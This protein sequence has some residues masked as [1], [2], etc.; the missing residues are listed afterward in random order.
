MKSTFNVV[1]AL[2]LAAICFGPQTSKAQHVEQGA[3]MIG[4]AISFTSIENDNSSNST[5]FSF[6][7][8]VAYFVANNFA[9]GLQLEYNRVK[10]PNSTLTSYGFAP[11]ARGYVVGGLFGQAEYGWSESKFESPFT[12]SK[13]SES[14]FAIGAGYTAFLNNSVALE[15]L[16]FYS[17]EDDGNIFGFRLGVQAFLGRGNE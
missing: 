14:A 8:G 16:L 11:L 6:Y 1:I 4:G 12:E 13:K 2:A 3:M 7:P 9:L 5:V 10:N 17:F 15:P